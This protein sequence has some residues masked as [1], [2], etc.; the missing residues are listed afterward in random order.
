MN[1]NVGEK[2]KELRTAKSLTQA[3]LAEKIGVTT[4][5]VSSYEV[6]A[7]QPS[8]DVLVKVS[9]LFN[10]TTDYLLGV[11]DKDVIDITELSAKQRGIIREI[12]LEFKYTID[13][14]RTKED[15]DEVNDYLQERYREKK[16]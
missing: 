14:P 12:V 15:W 10:V 6:S 8:Y 2:I 1:I 7:R 3:E 11:T 9:R 4:S 5:A 13:I 16:K